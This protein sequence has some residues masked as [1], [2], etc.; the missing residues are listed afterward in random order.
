MSPT[1]ITV[2]S[3]AANLSASF[4]LLA[5]PSAVSRPICRCR[6]DRRYQPDRPSRRGV[7]RNLLP[8]IGGVVHRVSARAGLPAR[9]LAGL[10]DR[11]RHRLFEG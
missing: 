6:S 7:D 3:H 9:L 11:G 5:W 8:D 2:I 4:D 10:D 1:R